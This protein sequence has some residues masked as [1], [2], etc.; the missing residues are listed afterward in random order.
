[1]M[2]ETRFFWKAVLDRLI[3]WTAVGTWVKG[4]LEVEF[5]SRRRAS[6]QFREAKLW[7][8]S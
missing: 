2:Q 3:M 8:K 4:G 5:P 6:I 1:L 7:Q